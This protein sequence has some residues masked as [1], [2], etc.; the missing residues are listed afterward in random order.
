[1]T[2]I[3]PFNDFLY[4]LFPKAKELGNDINVL[5]SEIN[6][7]YT[8]GNVKPIIHIGKK[9]VTI[10]IDIPELNKESVEFSKA[11]KLCEKRKY[12]YAKPILVKLIKKNQTVSEYHRVLG[13][14][15]FDENKFDSALDFFIDAL[16]WDPLNVNAL[17]M[18]GNI[19]AKHKSDI[20]AAMKYYDQVLA[21]NPNDSIA[22]N[23]IGANLM[24]LGKEDEA[25]RYFEIAYELNPAYPNTTYAFALIANKKK[26]YLR[27][28]GYAINS[29]KNARKTEP[30]FNH[31]VNLALE[32]AQ[33]YIKE[34]AGKILIEKYLQKLETESEKP[35]EVLED[36]SIPTAAKIEL[37]E[38]HNRDKHVV[39]YKSNYPSYEHLVMHE[40][41][42]LEFFIQARLLEGGG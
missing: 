38:N 6:R 41:T 29:L 34:N 40:L 27:S 23:N 16:K 19:F 2:I 31:S 11:I 35:V 13:Q 18:M 24:Q 42:H 3:F 21:I 25:L 4:E 12:E 26:E 10:T 5:E 28:F 36:N 20:S 33:E 17:I 7:Y 14:I 22:I 30:I 15:Y 39:R 9:F 1:M 8:L 37:A 32:S